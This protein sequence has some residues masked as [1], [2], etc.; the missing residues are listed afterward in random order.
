MTYP[1]RQR[2]IDTRLNTFVNL[3]VSPKMAFSGY[4]KLEAEETR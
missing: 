1:H 4:L 3:P 2:R